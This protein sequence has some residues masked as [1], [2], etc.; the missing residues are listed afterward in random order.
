M[1]TDKQLDVINHY[2]SYPLWKYLLETFE[3]N[4]VDVSDR[5][6]KEEPVLK[7]ESGDFVVRVVEREMTQVVLDTTDNNHKCFLLNAINTVFNIL[8]PGLEK[9]GEK[10]LMGYDFELDDQ[11]NMFLVNNQRVPVSNK[12]LAVMKL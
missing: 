7:T 10:I 4:I 6:C 5:V 12:V 11:K 2:G 1:A 3:I 9:D 8:R